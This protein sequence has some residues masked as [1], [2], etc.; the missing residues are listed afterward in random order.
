MAST[1]QAEKPRKK[2]QI[3]RELIYEE[4]DGQPI[5]Y[6]GYQEVIDNNKTLDD[7]MGSSYLQ[8]VII[9]H[10]FKYLLIH[11]EEDGFEVLSSELGLHL[12]KGSNLA[13]DIAIYRTEQLEG[14]E[15]TNKYISIPPEVVLEV[16]TKADLSELKWEDYLSQKNKKLFAFGVKKA[17]WV[18]SSSQQVILAEP[19]QDWLMRDWNKSFDI[20]PGH[21][22]NLGEML[23]KKGVK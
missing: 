15:L 11:V 22:V 5:Y 14:V 3:P 19:D 23:K 1:I 20:L 12:K 7:I 2:K 10:L 4:M 8:S 13:A 18:L 17:I 9:K 6:A 21:S 16:D